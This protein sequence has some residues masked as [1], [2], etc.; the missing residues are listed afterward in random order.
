MLEAGLEVSKNPV[1]LIGGVKSGLS[2]PE[3]VDFSPNG[4]SIVV[5][6]T[7]EYSVT[8][9]RR[10]GVSGSEYETVPF[11]TIKDPRYLKYPHDVAFSRNGDFFAAAGR[12]SHTIA[13]YRKKGE[14]F[15]KN[16]Y[17]KIRGP[18]SYL[19]LP[20]GISFS[21]TDN[22]IAVTNRLGPSTICFYEQLSKEGYYNQ[23][24]VFE[25]TEEMLKPYDLSAAH[26]VS[27]SQDGNT[28][29]L[30]HKKPY[31]DSVGRSAIVI[32]E[33]DLEQEKVVFAV[34]SIIDFG[35]ECLHSI[36]IHPSG[37]Y[38]ALAHER[39]DIMIFRKDIETHIFTPYRTISVD[40]KGNLEGPKG[41]AFSRQG[42]SL[43][44]TTVESAVLIYKVW[45]EDDQ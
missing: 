15:E 16:L 13:F 19:N 40:K 44:I 23:S 43:A 25:I 27:F 6:N 28:V 20:S 7:D 29:A 41:V 39:E 8:L 45:M 17:H 12:N 38:I 33:K 42:D 4:D 14:E 35:D 22:L 36:S 32:L 21:P 9:Y 30:V 5:S 18:K 31:G 3:G 10:I 2:R 1:T 37:E 26:G 11:K 24:P 34:S